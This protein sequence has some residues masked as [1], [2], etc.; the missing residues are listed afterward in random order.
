[1]KAEADLYRLFSRRATLL[2]GGKLALLGLIGARMYQLQVV[3]AERY[4]TLSDDNRINLQLI[5]PPRGRFVDR[6]GEPL[7][8]DKQNYRVSLVLEKAGSARAVL[9]TLASVLPLTDHELA[10]IIREIERGRR[11]MPIIVRENLTW[12]EVAAIEVNAPDLPGVL[13][14]VGRTRYYPYAEAMAH[15][16]GRAHV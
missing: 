2:M 11:F 3:E 9:E 6:Y 8:F 10:R 7:A 16:I 15:E 4:V 14:D 5:P 12:D 13:I 1:M